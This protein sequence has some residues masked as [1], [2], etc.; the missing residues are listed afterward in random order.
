MLKDAVASGRLGRIVS[1]HA[2]R[3]RRKSL[4][5]RYNRTHPCVENSIHDIDILLWYAAK[6]VRKVRG[7]GRNATGHPHHDT[8]W[9]VLE[10]EGGAIGVVETIWLLPDNSGVSLDDQLQVIGDRGIGNINLL[11]GPLTI[12]SEEGPQTVD[13][14]YDPLV[15]GEGTSV[16]GAG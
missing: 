5:P 7:Y 12:W 1:M 4:L 15:G 13:V 8:F 2:R 14:N 6:P 16:A 3:N 10:F 11:P 9:G